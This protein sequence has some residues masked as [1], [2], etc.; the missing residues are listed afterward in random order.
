MTDNNPNLTDAVANALEAIQAIADTTGDIDHELS[1]AQTE[2][3]LA[4]SDANRAASKEA[5]AQ[6]KLG[7]AERRLHEAKMEAAAEIEVLKHDNAFLA[8]HDSEMRTEVERL[9]Q[10]LNAKEKVAHR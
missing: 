6:R 10:A 2:V 4:R 8:K 3:A 7:Q 9:T 5:D 1:A